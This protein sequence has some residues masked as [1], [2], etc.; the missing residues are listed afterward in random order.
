MIFGKTFQ[1]QNI[2][3]E[4]SNH[5]IPD[6]VLNSPADKNQVKRKIIGNINFQPFGLINSQIIFTL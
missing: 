2:T 4:Y 3:S 1:G 6:S 5:I